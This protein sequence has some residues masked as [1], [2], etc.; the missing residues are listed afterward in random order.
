MNNGTKLWDHLL[1]EAPAGAILMG[2]A[3]VDYA[4]D[5]EP[6]DFDIFHTYKVGLPDVPENWVMTDANFNDPVWAEAHKQE[7]LQGVEANGAEPIGSVYEYIVDGQYKVQLIGVQ[8]DNPREHFKNFDHSLTLAWYG[9]PGLFVSRKVF[10]TF[11]DDTIRYVGKNKSPKA[12]MRSL[13]R[14][15]A[16]AARYGGEWKFAGF[17]AEVKVEAPFAW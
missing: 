7:Y 12:V 17:K 11:D 5:Q 8:Y 2:G 13:I 1:A 3:V 15:E 16:K 4:A 6:K 9:K 14:A 10:R